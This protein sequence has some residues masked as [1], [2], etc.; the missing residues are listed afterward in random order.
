M[1]TAVL[2]VVLQHTAASSHSLTDVSGGFRNAFWWAIGFTAAAV[3]LCLLL[4]RPR[5]TSVD[6]TVKVPAET[7]VEL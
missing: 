6:P 7:T 5:P 3:P 2:A 1:G 4:P